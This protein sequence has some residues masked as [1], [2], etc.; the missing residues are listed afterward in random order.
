MLHF[1]EEKSNLPELK[2]KI[3]LIRL[4]LARNLGRALTYEAQ[5]VQ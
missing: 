5:M 2:D 1:L 4:A 3:D